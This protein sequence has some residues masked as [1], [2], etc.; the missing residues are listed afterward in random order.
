MT[1]RILFDTQ[2]ADG[3]KAELYEK[4]GGTPEVYVDG[5]WG[6]LFSRGICKINFYTVAAAL[7]AGVPAEQQPERREIA[8]RLTMNSPALIELSNYL[9]RQIDR[10]AQDGVLPIE[11]V[12]ATPPPPETKPRSKSRRKKPK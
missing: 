1:E 7:T 4:E 6:F 3:R 9:V 11:E 10:L 5:A 8:V 2:L 12:S